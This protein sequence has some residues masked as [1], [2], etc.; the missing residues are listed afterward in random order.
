MKF[1]FRKALCAALMVALPVSLAGCGGSDAPAA[2]GKKIVHVGGTVAVT[3]GTMDPAKDWNG[4][5]AVRYGV[6]ET[7]FRL[8][9]EMKAQPWLAEKAENIEP[10]VWRITLKDNVTFSNGEKMTAEKVIESLKRTAETNDRAAWLKDAVFTAEG[11]V[12]T[13]KTKESYATLVNDLCD[14][15]AVILDV[16]GTKDFDNAPIGTGPFILTAFDSEKSAVMEKNATYWGGEVKLDGLE[17]T[18]IADFNTLATALQSGEIDVALD[19]SPETAETIAKSDKHTLVKTPQSRTYQLYFNLEKLTDPAVREAIMYGVDKKTIGDNV[20][21]GAM[22]ASGS[23]FL[24]ATPFGDPALKIRAFDAEKAK[25]V[26][27]AAGYADSDGDGIVEKNGKPLTV[28]MGVYKR[29]FNENITTEMQAQLKK[30]GI[31]VEIVPHEK[32]N[33]LKPGDFE[34]SLYSVVTMPTG[35][36]Y[37]FLRDTM[38]EKGA[39][40]FSRYHSPAVQ[41]M[42]A[43]LPNTFDFDKRVALV[44]RIQQQA[45]N[46]GAMD[47]IGFNNMLTGISK[48]VTGFLTSPSDYYQV[49]KDLDKK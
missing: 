20:L 29:L 42:L 31:N 33:Y 15:Y 36:P 12:L 34:M 10:T 23:A 27:A 43:E 14:P 24:A 28:Q 37:A 48:N 38:S 3:S 17:Y 30:I 32:A 46:D 8:D 1:N 2:G 49:S 7:L 41:G 25:A 47:F 21:K 5:Y 4:W 40:N 9:N 19:L 39:A 18:R 35:D 22:T 44:N 26:L 16:A 13:I 45:I 6:G 11:N